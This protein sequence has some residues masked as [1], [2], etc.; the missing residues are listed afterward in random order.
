MRKVRRSIVLRYDVD[1]SLQRY[2]NRQG[3]K[4]GDLSRFVEDAIAAR[5]FQ[6]EVRAVKK[7]NQR[8]SQ[9]E[10]L[11]AIDEALAKG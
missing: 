9:D 11:E 8:Y 3:A 2:L 1:K 5:L 6:F 10:I 4:K 7:R